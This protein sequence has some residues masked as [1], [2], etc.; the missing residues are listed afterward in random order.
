MSKMKQPNEMNDD[1]LRD[2]FTLYCG[3]QSR[4]VGDE[5]YISLM[6]KE[7]EKRKAEQYDQ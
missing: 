6:E 3:L 2:T 1:E 4:G 7:L 5:V